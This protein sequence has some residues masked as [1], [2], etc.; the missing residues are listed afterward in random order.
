[1]AVAIIMR[2]ADVDPETYDALGEELGVNENPPE[3]LIFHW[4]GEVDG[5]W[6]LNDVWSR[7]SSSTASPP[8]TSCRRCRGSPASGPRRRRSPS[9]GCTTTSSPDDGHRRPAYSPDG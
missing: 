8:I 2:L 3:G 5:D 9:R 7:A 1:M 4:A 6:T